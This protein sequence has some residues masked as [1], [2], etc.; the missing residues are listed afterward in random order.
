MMMQLTAEP[1]KLGPLLAMSQQIL[2]APAGG[3]V[4]VVA[5]FTAPGLAAGEAR[6][7]AHEVGGEIFQVGAGER[8]EATVLLAVALDGLCEVVVGPPVVAVPS[9]LA[10]WSHNKNKIRFICTIIQTMHI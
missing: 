4:G 10:S 1:G 5:H 6:R 7:A 2:L 3:F 8:D 9:V